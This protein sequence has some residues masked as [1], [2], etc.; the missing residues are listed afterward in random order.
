MD[1]PVYANTGTAGL[2]KFL[3]SGAWKKFDESELMK[4]VSHVASFDEEKLLIQGSGTQALIKYIFAARLAE[5]TQTAFTLSS[6]LSLCLARSDRRTLL[7][8]EV[9]LSPTFWLLINRRGQELC[10][11]LDEETAKLVL[12]KA[13]CGTLAQQRQI[14]EN[15]TAL[16]CAGDDT[17]LPR[18]SSSVQALRE[19]LMNSD[20]TLPDVLTRL[21]VAHDDVQLADAVSANVSSL[22]RLNRE[23]KRIGAQLRDADNNSRGVK[24]LYERRDIRNLVS[25][26][27]DVVCL[28]QGSSG[29]ALAYLLRKSTG[30]MV[31]VLF[32]GEDSLNTGHRLLLLDQIESAAGKPVMTELESLLAEGLLVEPSVVSEFH[33]GL[34]AFELAMIGLR[35]PDDA[36]TFVS[37]KVEELKNVSTSTPLTALPDESNELIAEIAILAYLLVGKHVQQSAHIANTLTTVLPIQDLLFYLWEAHSTLSQLRSLDNTVWLVDA[38]EGGSGLLISYLYRQITGIEQI[39]T[40]TRDLKK[41]KFRMKALKNRLADKEVVIIDDCSMTG[42]QLAELVGYVRN[43]FNVEE[44]SVIAA[45]ATPGAKAKVSS[46]CTEFVIG[47]EISDIRIAGEELLEDMPQFAA[48][49]SQAVEQNR[50]G[51]GA[52]ITGLVL[53]HMVPN[54]TARW[55]YGLLTQWLDLPAAHSEKCV[56]KRAA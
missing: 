1:T 27:V 47:Q 26:C 22:G 32:A 42:S 7:A 14:L 17:S 11:Q 54:N 6:A 48:L 43:N 46:C 9:F 39:V 4:L 36:R 55:L 56:V 12:E 49:I 19:R 53:P 37:T 50:Y 31:N 23:L 2:N 51:N 15:L 41:D 10:E 28:Y 38:S 29:T 18:T 33:L 30:I 25:Q 3:D 20:D 21:G 24:F 5:T 13:K 16:A 8:G 45:V 35:S 34:N 44:V 52:V 40:L